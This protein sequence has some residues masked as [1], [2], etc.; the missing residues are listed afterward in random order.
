MVC[1][2]VA[3]SEV[4][5]GKSRDAN[6]G[7]RTV[8]SSHTTSTTRSTQRMRGTPMP[9]P[10]TGELLAAYAAIHEAPETTKAP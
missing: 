2:G 6:G 8:R 1:A 5:V 3:R 9:D 4:L 7:A 10:T